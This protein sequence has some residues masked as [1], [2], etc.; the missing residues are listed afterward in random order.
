M[1]DVTPM[2]LFGVAV[3]LLAVGVGLGWLA[4]VTRQRTLL[5]VLQS[6]VADLSA[7]FEIRS[8]EAA[9]L[10]LRVE[11]LGAADVKCAAL[12]AQLDAER[13]SNDD[14]V[15][16]IEQAEQRLREAFQSMGAEALRQNSE[17][18]LQLARTS[19]SEMQQS[20]SSDLELR[21][22]AIS[23]MVS[24]IKETL[25]KM[26]GTIQKV[27]LARV[28]S[29][30]S[31]IEQLRSMGE[32]QRELS[33]RTK[34]LGEALRSPTV[35]GRWG[36]MQLKRV[37]EMAGMLDHCDFTE[38]TTIDSG[39][40][41]LRPDLTV[42][43]PGGKVIIVDAKAPLMAYLAAIE[44][45][46]EVE[47]ERLMRDHSRQVR[48]HMVKLGQKAYWGQFEST[49]EFVVMFLPG[50]TFFSAALQYDPGLIEYGFDQHVIPSS[51][52]TLIAL[53]RSIAYGWQQDRIAKNAE[54]ISALGK[55]MYS[56]ISTFS[57][58]FDTLRRSL[59]KSVEAYNSAVGSLERKVLPQARKFR[60]LG[61]GTVAE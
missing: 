29:Y 11:Q 1:S 26:D 35:R 38:Q 57:N 55:E 59:E 40:G 28:G 43:L 42:R 56:R 13:K 4:A 2:V 47:R 15:A 39:D 20:T 23:E 21:Q 45:T 60:D 6:R 33:G 61:A 34:Q 24:P 17:S 3:A 41:K 46:D 37:C 50:E 30:E 18:F 27:E 44:C 5:G 25:E 9:R 10:N 16:V 58:H 49:P 19:L 51:P 12:T 7:R 31:L 53:L 48:D 22:Q 32:T 14:K 8:A 52:T 36:E 54:E